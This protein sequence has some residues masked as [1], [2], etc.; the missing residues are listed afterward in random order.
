MTEQDV[1]YIY[2][3]PIVSLETFMGVDQ[4]TGE[5]SNPRISLVVSKSERNHGHNIIYIYSSFYCNDQ[6]SK[7]RIYFV[8]TSGAERHRIV[9]RAIFQCARAYIM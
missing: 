4:R 5:G 8:P 1:L 7:L 9:H 6:C 2:T 3:I